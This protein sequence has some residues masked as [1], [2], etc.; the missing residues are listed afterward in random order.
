[1]TASLARIFRHPIKSIGA[2]ELGQVVLGAGQSLPLDREWAVLNDRAKVTRRP[3]GTASE[4]GRKANFLTG[5]AGPSLIAVTA[6]MQED[7]RLR[8]DHPGRAPIEV[9]P[10]APADQAR[11]IDWLRP[12]WPEDAPAPVAVVRAPGRPLTDESVPYVSLIG[13]ASLADLSARA[14]V[15]LSARRFRA[16]LWVEGWAPLAELDLIGRDIR[17]GGAVLRP[18]ARIGRCRATDANPE[19][20]RRDIDMLP[21]LER[22]YGHTD[23]GVFCT[24]VEGGAITRGDRVEVL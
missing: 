13:T 22:S 23:L 15:P 14:G 8:L 19:T 12:I 2:E 10:E 9:D 5:R 18:V 17:V 24:V 16:N 4:W 7:G 11:L 1:M 21:L 20:G 3:D 6:A